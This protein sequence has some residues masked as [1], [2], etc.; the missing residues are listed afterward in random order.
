MWI[1]SPARVGALKRN[2]FREVNEGLLTGVDMIRSQPGLVKNPKVDNGKSCHHS[3]TWKARKNHV[4]E[5]GQNHS[6]GRRAGGMRWLYSEECSRFPNRA[7]QD[8]GDANTHSS[9]VSSISCWCLHWLTLIRRKRGRGA[10]DV[11]CTDQLLGKR[12]GQ[13]G[14]RQPENNLHSPII[15]LVFPTPGIIPYI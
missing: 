9:S 8:E 3:F 4:I 1:V 6:W 15:L 12:A 2:H 10:S 11:V 13:G 5:L 7:W 14:V